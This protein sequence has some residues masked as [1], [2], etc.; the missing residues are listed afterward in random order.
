MGKQNLKALSQTGLVDDP[1]TII[2]VQGNFFGAALPAA[3]IEAMIAAN[4]P[5]VHIED[6]ASVF[7][8]RWWDYRKM[9]PGHSFYLFAHHY[10]AGCRSA[11]RNFLAEKANLRSYQD[12][13]SRAFNLVGAS[14]GQMQVEDIWSKDQA[15]ITGVW[16]AMLVADAFGIPY[17]VYVRLACRI[18]LQRL[19]KRLPRP[20]QL[21]SDNLAAAVVEEWE[22]LKLERPTFAKHPIYAEENYMGLDLQDAYREW[23]IEHI[24][25]QKDKLSAIMIAVYHSRQIPEAM[26]LQHFPPQLVNRARLLSN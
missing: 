24:E 1:V 6:V 3:R 22:A 15:H 26:A 16:K 2:G 8:T 11:A 19:W 23:L 20:S 7:E 10:Y 5:K 9:A 17:D 21:Y 25:N 13:K 4:V 14:L 12:D 18:A